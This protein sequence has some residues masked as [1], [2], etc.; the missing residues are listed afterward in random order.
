MLHAYS[1]DISAEPV[2]F[3]K[4]IGRI[5]MPIFAYLIVEGSLYA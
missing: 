2:L 5:A 1:P 4:G 3:G